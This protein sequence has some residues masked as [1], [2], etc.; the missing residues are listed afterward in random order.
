M[1][2]GAAVVHVERVDRRMTA[3]GMAESMKFFEGD[4][5]G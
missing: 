4:M 5:A 1:S 2:V 3:K